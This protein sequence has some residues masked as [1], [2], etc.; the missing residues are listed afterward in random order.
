[1]NVGFLQQAIFKNLF[2]KSSFAGSVTW[3]KNLSGDYSF[4]ITN[5]IIDISQSQLNRETEFVLNNINSQKY[6][7]RGIFEA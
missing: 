1:M 6:F 4:E 7:N 2:V 3:S 5:N